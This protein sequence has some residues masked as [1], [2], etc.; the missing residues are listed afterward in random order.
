MDEVLFSSAAEAFIRIRRIDQLSELMR[1]M[2]ERG[3][4]L[5]L[6][7]PCYGS[8][9]KAYGNA[10]DVDH[11]WQLWCEMGERGV[12]PTSITV[13]CT[14]DALVKNSRVEDAWKLVQELSQ[15]EERRHYVNTVIYSTVL[16]GFAAARK[17]ARI[18]S[19]LAEM[20]KN[21][22]PC[23]T[24][25]YNTMIDA[26]ARCGCMDK[27]PQLLE[28]MK[29]DHVELDVITYS[30][31]VKGYCHAGDV[32]KAFK[33]LDEMK[34][35]GK[36]SPDEILYNSLLDG[37]AKQCRVDDAVRLLEDMRDCGVVP[38]NFTLSIMVKLMGR[39]RRLDEAFQLVDE[40]G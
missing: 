5:A 7:A 30:T 13:G 21:G 37:C 1:Q 34:S 32:D 29:R 9:I 31:L 12:R 35:D 28:E 15:D 4:C 25:T 40:L 16:K 11:V 8:M 39:A 38:S 20:R 2:Q 6:T 10:G 26:C 22:V 17:P 3:L 36:L 23:N 18:F 33:V 27:V 24:I 14:V 19:V